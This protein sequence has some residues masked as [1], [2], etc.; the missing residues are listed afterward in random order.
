MIQHQFPLN[1][2]SETALACET[3]HTNVYSEYTCY[4]CHEH[5]PGETVNKHRELNLTSEELAAC[6]QCHP[7]GEKSEAG[8]HEDE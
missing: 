7:A 2:G 5:Q 4:G 8:E 3:C 1:H 6:V